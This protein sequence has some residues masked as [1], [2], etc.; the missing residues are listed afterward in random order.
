A[1]GYKATPILKEDNK[2]TANMVK[3]DLFP[4]QIGQYVDVRTSIS[5]P[6]ACAFCGFPQH[7]GKYQTA[8]KEA[9]EKE[10]DQLDKIETLKGIKFIDDTFNVPPAR[11]KEILRMMIKKRYKFKWISNFRAQFADGE[12]VRL[13]KESGCEAVYMGIE[14]GS[15]QILKNMNK[16]ATVEDYKRGITLLNQ[17]GII[18]FA[19]FII[20]F[21]GETDETVKETIAF[22]K[23]SGIT[24]FRVSQWFCEH[25]TPIW[26]QRDTYNIT[27]ESFEWRHATM[28][29][30]KAM[31][32]VE[33]IFK[34]IENPIWVPIYNFDVDTMWHLLHQGIPLEK[35]KAF[36]GWFNRGV[37]DKLTGH[38][39]ENVRIEVLQQL[40]KTCKIPTAALCDQEKKGENQGFSVDFDLD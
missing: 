29:S 1:D 18:T 37:R 35:I 27:G 19:S 11:F 39:R 12:T 32:W 24:F 5:C 7:A 25:I 14:S 38:P 6:F 40:K 36:L 3:W 10:L 31:D 20:G 15:N 21:P 30:E 2:L 8:D 23:E 33:E 17:Y 28:D 16:A 26:Q 13:M 4:G 22:I 9:L 34:T